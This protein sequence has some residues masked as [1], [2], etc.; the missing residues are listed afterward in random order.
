MQQDARVRDKVVLVGLNSPV[1]RKDENADE[2][3]LEE[4]AALVETAG[5][6]V[7]GIV[8]QNRPSPDPRCFIGE[9]KV[10]EVKLYCENVG[11]SM[12]IFDNDLAPCS[13]KNS[14]ARRRPEAAISHIKVRRPGYILNNI[15]AENQI[16][17]KVA[18]EDKTDIGIA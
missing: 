16:I 11:A 1:L 12:V 5:G 7:E 14:P 2:D 15:L 9:G 13:S 6:E 3:T 17:G 8:M 4:L 10:A 18:V